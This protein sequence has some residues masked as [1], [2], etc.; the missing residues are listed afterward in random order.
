MTGT[1][2]ERAG[3]GKGGGR[4]YIMYITD[5]DDDDDEWFNKGR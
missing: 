1:G 5:D 3:K 4:M 2:D